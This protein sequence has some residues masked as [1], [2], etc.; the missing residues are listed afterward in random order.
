MKKI[1]ITAHLEYAWAYKIHGELKVFDVFLNSIKKR[2]IGVKECGSNETASCE[3]L[4][5][6]IEK[7]FYKKIA[8]R[9]LDNFK[10]EINA[11]NAI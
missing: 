2:D 9:C 3:D 7:F 1:K 5:N 8:H 6:A 11:K 4:F 10:V